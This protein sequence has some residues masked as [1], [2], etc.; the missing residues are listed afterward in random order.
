MHKKVV[1]SYQTSGSRDPIWTQV[2]SQPEDSLVLGGSR[3]GRQSRRTPQAPSLNETVTPI[4]MRG[5]SVMATAV[6]IAGEMAGSGVLALPRAVVDTGW[7]GLI[8]VVVFCCCAAYS[9]SRLGECWCIIEERYHQYR[10]KTR[11]P[12]A[13]IAHAACG[14]WASR[15]VSTCIQITLFG[16]GTV[17]LL[18]ASNIAQDMMQS[19][20]PNI[21][22]C[23]YLILIAG[24]LC[25]AMWL[26]SPK[27]FWAVGIGALLTTALAC[28]C[29][30][31]K[32]LIDS[33]GPFHPREPVPTDS[34]ED[35]QTKVHTLSKLFLS[36]GTILFSFGGASTFPTIQN[37]MKERSRFSSS[38]IIG[39][40]VIL[41]L[42][43]P[44]VIGGFI[45]YGDKVD[46]NILLS[47]A[48]GISGADSSEARGQWLVD[49]AYLLMGAHL[50][51]AFL[52]V[53][54]P[55]CQEIEECFGIPHYFGWRRCVIRTAIMVA[56][57]IVGETVPSFGKLLAL[58]G[59]STVTLLTFVLPPLFYMRLCDQD[60]P[61]LP[62][63]RGLTPAG[64]TQT[65][66]LAWP[67]RFIPLH[68]RV[69]LWELIFVGLVGGTASTV[70]AVNGIFGAHSI[71]KPCYL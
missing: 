1:A 40:S 62:R 27:D 36:F 44:V 14:R 54:N 18:L 69:L 12:Y 41:C 31:S 66:E 67:K 49:G 6:L 45:L 46:P 42:Y 23:L 70:S 4:N 65:I 30:F 50:V 57:V 33:M 47:L 37:D 22:F 61:S 63:R 35:H 21:S 43:L 3:H 28:A 60:P 5:L 48:R 51:L 26:G 58:V 24:V 7:I 52:I 17:Y 59:G 55:V 56:M 20:M 16:A 15:L 8:L 53:V 32:M 19:V 29:I 39:F 11:N 64:S 71:D 10:G 68:I 25:P 9:G 38:V 34:P 13:T 2:S